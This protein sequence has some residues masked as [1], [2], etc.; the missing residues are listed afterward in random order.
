MWKNVKMHV[1]KSGKQRRGH[2]RA[3]AACPYRAQR[4]V[5]LPLCLCPHGHP[6]PP[7]IRGQPGHATAPSARRGT[8]EC[9]TFVRRASP[10]CSS[11]PFLLTIA[12]QP[13]SGTPKSARAPPPGPAPPP[14]R[15]ARVTDTCSAIGRP[16]SERAP[17]SLDAFP[18]IL[19]RVIVSV[20]LSPPGLVT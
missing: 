10:T 12:R 18:S 2:A 3:C 1:L 6:S 11:R 5:P 14:A 16:L 15:S 7:P 17:T 19:R 13:G 9:A 4:W 20:P 8:G